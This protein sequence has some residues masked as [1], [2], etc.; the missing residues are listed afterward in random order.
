MRPHIAFFKR[1]RAREA[2]KSSP[3]DLD[4]PLTWFQ[5]IVGALHRLPGMKM[6]YRSDV[7][8]E[9][10]CQTNASPFRRIFRSKH[11][12]VSRITFDEVYKPLRVYK[13]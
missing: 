5:L 9:T 13:P 7:R 12:I 4:A 3:P 2:L 6:R 1:R 11:F 10:D 8:K